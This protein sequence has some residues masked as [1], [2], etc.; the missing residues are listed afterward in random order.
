MR[1]ILIIVRSGFGFCRR[2]RRRRL[3]KTLKLKSQRWIPCMIYCEAHSGG[4]LA[5]FSPVCFHRLSSMSPCN[6]HWQKPFRKIFYKNFHRAQSS[7]QYRLNGLPRPMFSFPHTNVK[8]LREQ[9]ATKPMKL[10]E[11]RYFTIDIHIEECKW[12][13]ELYGTRKPGLMSFEYD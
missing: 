1:S 9:T 13:K 6:M 5:V 10:F 11:G 7:S 3:I 12:I 2:H 4:S 8:I